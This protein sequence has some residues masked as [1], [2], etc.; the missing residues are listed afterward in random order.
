MSSRYRWLIPFFIIF[1]T[2]LA[3]DLISKHIIF[4]DLREEPLSTVA[5]IPHYVHLTLVENR[6]MIWG[7]AEQYTSYILVFNF[8]VIPFI[9]G[10]YLS[11]IIKPGIF[12]YHCGWTLSI[13]MALVLAGAIG[14]LVDRILLNYV[15]DFIDVTIPVI[16]YSWP[17]FN[18]ADCGISIG[19]GLVAYAILTDTPIPEQN[20]NDDP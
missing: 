5:I 17:V 1:S 3:A 4:E 12:V 9:F 15:R 14:N 10:L 2:W 6:G 7:L 8:L 20:D 11:S 13:G 16:E 19:T 18:V